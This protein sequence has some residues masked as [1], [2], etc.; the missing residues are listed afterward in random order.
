MLLVLGLLL[1][2]I[3]VGADA[4]ASTP[5]HLRAL[6]AAG[7]PN[8]TLTLVVKGIK[9]GAILAMTAVGLSLIFG[10]TGLINFAHGELVTIGAAIALFFNAM[11]GGPG[12]QLIAA[13]AIAIVLAGGFGWVLHAALWRPLTKRK[14]GLIQ[15][16]IISIGLSLLLRNVVQVL[17]GTDPRS[18]T[19]YRIQPEQRYGPISITHR[20]LVITIGSLIV[21][22]LVALMLQR[23]KI[24]K[25]MRAVADNRDLAE[26]SG[27]DVTR[28]VRFVWIM[29]TALAA[30]GGICYGLT[31]LVSSEMGFLLLLL[32]FAGIILGG[33]GTAYG[34]MLGCLL[35]GLVMQLST[36]WSPVEL[37]NAWALLVLV[38][39]L[40]VRPQGL[41]GR[42]ERVG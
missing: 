37:Q 39:V 28:V 27:I 36:L 33:L 2:G 29:G 35:I 40:L 38:L 5:D 13:G 15:L 6:A 1:A 30:L 41:L 9:F 25:A 26:A 24:G 17:I 7:P 32:I 42:R 14:T 4:L 3:F 23:T 12:L 11:S 20:D 16:F 19:D 8:R 22:L 21:L 18:Y 31:E 34:A 10:T